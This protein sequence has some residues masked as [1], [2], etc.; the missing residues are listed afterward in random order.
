MCGIGGMVR[1]EGGVE[2]ERDRLLAMRARLRHRGPDG[3]GLWL[4]PRVGLV[5]TR[6]ALLDPEHGA[7]PLVSPDGRYA[8]VYNGEV[9]NAPELRR[10]LADFWRFRTRC[11]AE[12]VL[13]AFARWGSEC[14]ARLDGMFAFF[15]W[16][17]V[18]EAGFAA[19][20][21][22]GV[23]PFVYEMRGPDDRQDATDIPIVGAVSASRPDEALPFARGVGTLVFASEAKALLAARGERPRARLDAL[24]EYLV[25]PCF[26]GVEAPAFEGMRYLP[27][28]HALR[29]TRES[30]ETWAWADYS[31]RAEQT[32]L[33]PA[34][35]GDAL[36]AAVRRTQVADAPVGVF[37]S[38]GLDS[39]AIAALM[40]RAGATPRAYTIAFEGQ[41]DFDYARSRIVISDDGPFASLAAEALGLE[42]V[43]VP[44]ARASLAADLAALA[45]SN[46][47][48]PAW[49]QELA[50][51]H[52]SRAASERE[53]AVL[54]GDA[55]DETHYGYH[56]LL[57][58]EATRSPRGVIE[59]FTAPIVRED[60][61][62][63]PVAHF[64][65]KYRALT[66][67]AGYGW[68]TREERLRATSWLVVRRW[69]PRLL[70]NGDVHGMAHSLEARVP[71]ADLA[72]L[73]LAQRVAPRDA[74]AGGVEKA[75]LREALRGVIPEPI[76][77]R[78][79]SALPKDQAVGAVY[80]REAS[81]ALDEVGP[82]LGV[83][84]DLAR[85]R[86]LCD[87]S[88]TLDERE[89]ALLFRLVGLAHW[90]RLHGVRM[91]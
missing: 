62:P 18:E 74:L 84:V 78:R 91:P 30:L 68:A 52:L 6:L 43:Q 4:R 44:V 72:L 38:G 28:G 46:D 63:D 77:T 64:D 50:Q 31:L 26:S 11:D 54:V 25:V 42:H 29:F 83:V 15:V 33:S 20:D 47:A 41:A 58:A 8:L 66:E 70:H 55:A 61:L 13:A 5:H 86:G 22:L 27:P 14:P 59:R 9:Y 19:R 71:F 49:E 85:A 36:A 67:A 90:V 32:D 48:L 81:R 82:E 88:R 17:S 60:V 45:A 23:K 16:D 65:A 12:V 73:A 24:L 53:K 87:P 34:E 37:L 76:R 57:D 89:R 35:L 39:T 1:F 56:F 75:F 80:R 40:R 10:E 3:D 79:K 21:M 51:H 2:R 7:Q 69:L